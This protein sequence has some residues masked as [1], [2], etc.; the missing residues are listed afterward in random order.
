M[1][2]KLTELELGVLRGAN[3]QIKAAEQRLKRAFES[4]KHLQAL[5]GGKVDL[6]AGTVEDAPAP[7]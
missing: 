5:A 7:D 1:P 3:D 2:R 4:Y 6:D